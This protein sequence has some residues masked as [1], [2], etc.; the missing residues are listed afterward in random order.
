MLSKHLLALKLDIQN[1]L[2]DIS[3]NEFISIDLETTGLD[4]N[5]NEIIEISAI[6]FIDGRVHSDFTTLVKPTTSI[7][8]EITKLTGITNAMVSESNSIDDVLDDLISFI[9]GKILIAHNI[10]FDLKFINKAID[11]KNKKIK[12]GYICDTLLLSRSFFFTLEK[13]NLEYLSS[14]FSLDHKNAH[15]AREDALNTGKIFIELIKQMISMP[16]DIFAQINQLCKTKTTYNQF[17]YTKI[18]SFLESIKC[19]EFES[20]LD[21]NLR[22]N[23]SDNRKSHNDDFSATIDSWF[24]D[25]GKLSKSWQDYSKRDIQLEFSSDIYSNFNSNSILISEAGAGLGKSLAYLIAGLKY[26]KENNKKLII[27]TF[28]K[29]LQEQLFYKDIP[30]LADDLDL[31]LKS[32]ILKGKNNYISKRKLNDILYKEHVY[33]SDKEINECITLLVWAYFT[34]TG[35]VEE[36]NG[37]NR[38]KINHLWNKVSFPNLEKTSSSLYGFISE[39]DYYDRVLKE[40]SDSDIIIINHALLCSDISNNTASL[41]KDSLLVVDEGHNFTN[42]VKNQLTFNFSDSYFINIVNSLKRLILEFDDT[43]DFISKNNLIKVIDCLLDESQE[44]FNL[45]KFNFEDTYLNLQFGSYDVLL[46]D[47]EFRLNGLDVDN[48]CSALDKIIREIKL[49]LEIGN[50][51]LKMKLNQLYLIFIEISDLKNILDIFSNPKSRHIKWV[52]LYKFGIKNYFKIYVSDSDTENFIMQKLCKHYPSFLMCSA[53]LTVNN[54]FDFF[55]K[56]SGF[57]KNS[58]E[59]LK[60]KVYDSPFYYEDQSKLYIYDKNIDINSSEYIN[61]IS[62]QIFSLNNSLNKRM[63]VLCTSYKQVRAITNNLLNNSSVDS[64]NIFTQTSRFSK[65]K[66]LDSY[67]LSKNGILIATA[68]FWEGVDLLGELLEILFIIRIPFSNPSNPYNHYLSTLIEAEGGNSFYDLQLPNAILKLKQGLGRLIR[69]DKD[70]GVCIMTDPR[71]YK[72]RY[73]KFIIDE[74][75]VKPNFYQNID[76]I[77]NE[78]DNF[79]G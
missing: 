6:K 10:E 48:V 73:G 20:V 26:S 13:F 37:I 25:G 9:E 69:S 58:C 60:T 19:N 5:E 11:N 17:L 3:F 65:K 53:T 74:L 63:L 76:E 70:T 16:I 45:F 68:T 59:D 29:T 77:I 27:S 24:E 79:L 71:L 22:S 30:V 47:E 55:F 52:S 21:F 61:D 66:I 67:K 75:S 39:N 7:P 35:D 1:V 2:K 46:S 49:I 4:A 62:N 8:P 50:S 18:F 44:V 64:R 31:N 32:V 43:N 36:C 15:R 12:F 56:T 33:M 57:N 78:I 38:E 41:P 72:S 51:K 42:A 28:T 14:L 54:S 23:V 40:V 34:Q